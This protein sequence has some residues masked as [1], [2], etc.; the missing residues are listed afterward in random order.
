VLVVLLFLCS[1]LLTAQDSIPLRP[2]LIDITPLV[3]Y[4][5]S[6]GWPIQ[7]EPGNRATVNLGS[8]L[9]YGFAIGFRVQDDNLLEFRW[10]RQDAYAEVRQADASVLTIDASTDRFHC[11]FIHEYAMR[12]HGNRLRPYIV[13]SVGA[14]NIFS[15]SSF[16]STHISVGIGGGV[17]FFVSR[18]LGFRMQAEWLPVFIRP[19]QPVPCSTVCVSNT[20]GTVASQGQVM[21]GPVIQF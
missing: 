19:Q 14:T 20:G 6:I 7:S 9:A 4:G 15:G 8:S 10:T 17:K 3:G 21:F 11:D 13:G 18:R 5:T 12:H 2:G 16:S 1:V